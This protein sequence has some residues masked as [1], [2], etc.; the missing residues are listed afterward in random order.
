MVMQNATKFRVEII[1]VHLL[2]DHELD[3]HIPKWR[4]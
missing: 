4:L 1:I 3:N 2:N